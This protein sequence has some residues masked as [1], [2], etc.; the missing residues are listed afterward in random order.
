MEDNNSII[1]KKRGRPRKNPEDVKDRTRKA[2][3]KKGTGK[4]AYATKG[5]KGEKESV[6]KYAKRRKEED[7]EINAGVAKKL[8]GE[9]AE[10]KSISLRKL[11]NGLTQ[12]EQLFVIEYCKD[13]AQNKLNLM[14]K[15]GSNPK[16][17]TS[18]YGVYCQ[19]IGRP[20]VKAA[21]DEQMLRWQDLLQQEAYGFV[22]R[23]IELYKADHSEVFKIKDGNVILMDSDDQTRV[24]RKLLQS[25]S[26]TPGE[27]GDSTN[28]K[29]IDT[30]PYHKM[31]GQWLSMMAN[32][33]GALSPPDQYQLAAINAVRNGERTAVEAAL[34]LEAVGAP[35]PETIRIMLQKPDIAV[36]ASV[37]SQTVVV[38]PE[39]MWE[40]RKA[41]LEA[42]DEEI[43]SF[44]PGRQ[45]EVREL[46]EALGQANKAFDPSLTLDVRE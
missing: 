12:R 5:A 15:C 1:P 39:E 26:V 13:P 2:T 44:V 19:M 33:R 7:A 4:I 34:D 27:F 18:A 3:A 32:T 16:S 38:S 17:E 25:V 8:D 46:K 41:K 24:G 31:V 37:E 6:R 14:R 10:K 45:Q 21:I 43:R 23:T 30:L 9:F 35:L 40:R 20:H 29:L 42:V 28:V 11:P 36:S 22:Q